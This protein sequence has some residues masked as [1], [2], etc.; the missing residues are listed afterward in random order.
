MIPASTFHC[1]GYISVSHTKRG[2]LYPLFQHRNDNIPYFQII[3]K[4][5]VVRDMVPFLIQFLRSEDFEIVPTLVS[6]K[7]QINEPCVIAFITNDNILI[8]GNINT[9]SDYYESLAT[10][11]VDQQIPLLTRLQLSR[12]F[13]KSLRD[14]IRLVKQYSDAH[15]SRPGAQRLYKLTEIYLHNHNS[16]IWSSINNNS[17]KEVFGNVSMFDK[18]DTEGLFIWLINNTYHSLWRFAWLDY[19]GRKEG[20]FELARIVCDTICRRNETLSRADQLDLTIVARLIR[21]FRNAGSPP[22]E[23]IDLIVDS[24]KDASLLKLERYINWKD[25]LTFVL[26]YCVER[27]GLS[28]YD[29]LFMII[30]QRPSIAVFKST[31]ETLIEAIGNDEAVVYIANPY[32]QQTI[33]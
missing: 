10:G 8:E 3:D 22:Q 5:F 2:F 11:E 33:R 19:S 26:T 21:I 32:Q 23:F 6:P 28:E 25:L 13:D 15:I 12:F 1:Q 27:S 30:N 16:K 29:L 9:I 7:I 17:N 31:A 4:D 18:L 20:E 14:K 24:L